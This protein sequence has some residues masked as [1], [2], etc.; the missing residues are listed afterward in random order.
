MRA[1]RPLSARQRLHS[2]TCG[3]KLHACNTTRRCERGEAAS[4]TP[5]SDNRGNQAG[6]AVELEIKLGSARPDGS[7]VPDVGA[8][9][10]QRLLEALRYTYSWFRCRTYALVCDR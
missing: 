5:P 4:T 7:F 9:R 6:A 1:G 8:A 10:F 3:S 2:P